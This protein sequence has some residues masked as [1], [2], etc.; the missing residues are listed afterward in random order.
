MKALR[1]SEPQDGWIEIAFMAGQA[2]YTVVASAVPNDC[3]SDLVQAL[4]RLLFG[5]G[6]EQ[7]QFSLEP[8]Y[9]TCHMR[10]DGAN[11]HVTILQPKRN[12]PVFEA[13]FPILPF[14]K[15]IAFECKRLQPVYGKTATWG[16]EYPAREVELLVAATKTMQDSS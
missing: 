9:A 12:E 5:S 14:A 8:E 7:V 3:V 15:R 11:L 1:F 4:V 13:T 16:W 2:N 6:A 10:R